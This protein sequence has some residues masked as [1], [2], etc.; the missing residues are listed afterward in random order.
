MVKDMEKFPNFLIVYD[1][2][3]GRVLS[4][5]VDDVNRVEMSLINDMKSD[6]YWR[7]MWVLERCLDD[8]YRALNFD[9]EVRWIDSEEDIKF[10]KYARCKCNGEFRFVGLDGIMSS[11]KCEKCGMMI[12]YEDYPENKYTWREMSQT[13]V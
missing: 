4:K 12:H 8:R 10:K 5:C 2:K 11:Y 3:N 7:P 13:S 9:F 6:D 1:N